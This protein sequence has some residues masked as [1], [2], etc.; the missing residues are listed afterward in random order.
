[1]KLSAALDVEVVA[2]E[3]ADEVTLL[4]EL[5]APAGE[6][7]DRT[8]T[9]LQVV[10][11]RSGSMSGP[12]LEG[13]QKA[14]AGVVAQ[15]DPADVFGLV[16]FDD[17]AQVVVPAGP[18]ADK[19]RAAGAISTVVPG[20]CTDLSSGYLRGLQELRRSAASA[21]IRGGTVLVISDGHV[22]RGI[23]DLDEFASITAKAAADGIVTSTLGYGRGYDE[24]LL[25]AMARSGN[26]NHV[27]AD[28]PDAAGAAIAGEVEGL[29]SKSAQAVTLTVR[30]VPQVQELSLYND[31]PAHQTADGEVMI[32]LGDL[33]ALEER[34]L[35]LR[36]KVDGLAALGLTQIASLELRYVETATL[37]E[38]TV[39]LP[40]SVNVVPGDELGPR[41]PNP[42]VQSERLYQEGQAAK[43]EASQAYESGD[44]AT[45][46]S[47]L[48][49]SH[50]RLRSAAMCAS[51]DD[52][53]VID[54]ELEMIEELGIQAPLAGAA[55]ASKATRDSYH[56]GNRKRGR[57]PSAG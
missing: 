7:A 49:A 29:L 11:D 3:A 6:V 5:Q 10:L 20:G 13:A 23:Q 36:M 4:L 42:T 25:S 47:R 39:A 55:Y 30:Y 50:E 31:L 33:Y 21:G 24:T 37:T 15:L 56:L 35:L 27:F 51:P 19:Q 12:P 53:A 44:L 52:R 14:L 18:L 46:Q 17:S 38:H 8:P 48:R 41:V 34:K 28:D 57:R 2:H 16:T 45:G 40:I 22:N 43:L 26:G 1:M 9:A 32:E 54:R